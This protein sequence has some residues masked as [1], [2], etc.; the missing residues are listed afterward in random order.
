MLILS[1]GLRGVPEE[2]DEAAQLEGASYWRGLFRVTLPIIRPTILVNMLLITIGTIG[3]FTLIYAMTQGGPG[4]STAILPVFMYIEAFT[5]NASGLWHRDRARSNG[6][7]PSYLGG[8]HPS[9][10]ARTS[11]R[12]VAQLSRSRLAPEGKALGRPEAAGGALT[13]PADQTGHT[14][15]MLT[16]RR[17]FRDRSCLPLADALGES[18]PPSVCTRPRCS[19][20]PVSPWSTFVPRISLGAGRVDREQP[21]PC[22]RVHRDRNRRVGPGSVRDI[23]PACTAEGNLACRDARACRGFRSLCCLSR[24]TSCTSISAGSTRPSTH[25]LRSRRPRSLCDL[26]AEELHRPSSEGVRGGCGDRGLGGMSILWRIIV[27][28]AIPAFLSQPSSP[29]SARGGR[30]FSPSSSTPTLQIRRR[31]SGF[32]TTSWR[33]LKCPTALWRPTQFCSLFLSSSCTWS[34]PGGCTGVSVLPEE[35]RGKRR[36]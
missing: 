7:W 2:V 33:T 12:T 4:T 9:T 16:Q 6:D 25:R 35:S 29:L 21:L 27:P 28:L 8:L 3:D 17:S 1:A 19:R 13:L 15:K 32:T 30:S 10:T 31:R 20:D 14:A 11:T 18:T 34:A 22:S 24:F 23:P 5:Y 26:A 36:E